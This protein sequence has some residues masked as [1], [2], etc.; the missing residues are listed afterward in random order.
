MWRVRNTQRKVNE[1]N[2]L[3]LRVC[4]ARARCFHPQPRP[5]PGVCLPP[6][7]SSRGLAS[8]APFPPTSAWGLPRENW[9]LCEAA[10]AAG[11]KGTGS[12]SALCQRERT[13]PSSTLQSLVPLPPRPPPPRSHRPASAVVSSVQRTSALGWWGEGSRLGH[14]AQYQLPTT[15]FGSELQ[16]GTGAGESGSDEVSCL[17][18]FVTLPNDLS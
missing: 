5:F 2:K 17:L 3:V 1:N 11:R 9:D 16:V 4:G 8:A 6:L 12:S 10:A 13:A 15:A 7:S 14:S 18:G